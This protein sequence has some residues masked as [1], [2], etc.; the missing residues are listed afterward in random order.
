MSVDRA[1]AWGRG[2][3]RSPSSQFA[4][5]G[6]GKNAVTGRSFCRPRPRAIVGWKRRVAGT[7][8]PPRLS[9]TRRPAAN[10]LRKSRDVHGGASVD[11]SADIDRWLGELSLDNEG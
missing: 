4:G 6:A 2:A 3:P 10:H 11:E 8:V 7:A 1:N 5:D 9:L